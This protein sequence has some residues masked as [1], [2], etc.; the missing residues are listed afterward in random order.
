VWKH[1]RPP[2]DTLP[3]WP[4]SATSFKV[5]SAGQLADVLRTGA[6]AALADTEL[7]AV[8][9]IEDGEPVVSIGSRLGEEQVFAAVVGL[10]ET[11]T[12]CFVEEPDLACE[13]GALL[14]A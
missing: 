14:S 8:T 7:D 1:E 9:G 4:T 2:G 6:S 10:D 12:F 5:I 3:K 13:Y 11:I